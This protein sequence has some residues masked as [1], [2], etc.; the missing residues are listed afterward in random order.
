MMAWIESSP[1]LVRSALWLSTTITPPDVALAENEKVEAKLTMYD[2]WDR[3]AFQLVIVPGYTPRSQ[4]EAVPGVHPSP[5]R[6]WRR[7]RARTA[8]GRR[9]SSWS[10]AAT[11]TRRARPTTR[12]SR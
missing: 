2:A 12:A 11:S 6:A 7:P 5:A 9:P 3:H 1:E 10:A 4:R 8:R